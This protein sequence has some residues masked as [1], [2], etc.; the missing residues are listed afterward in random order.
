VVSCACGQQWRGTE[1]EL[2]AVV[3]EHGRDVHNM[4]ATADQV[5]AMAVDLNDVDGPVT[6]V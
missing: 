5:R 4:D 3:Q 6:G 2:I 1:A